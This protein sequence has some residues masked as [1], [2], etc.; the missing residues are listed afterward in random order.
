MKCLK[1]AASNTLPN[2]ENLV[3]KKQWQTS[4]WSSPALPNETI[5]PNNILIYFNA[6]ILI[7]LPLKSFNVEF[8]WKNMTFIAIP[9][10][11]ARTGF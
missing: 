10:F 8:C 2:T 9:W 4:H 7:T 6:L 5:N 1:V 11:G 3:A